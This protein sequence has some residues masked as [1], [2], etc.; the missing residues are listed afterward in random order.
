MSY[1]RAGGFCRGGLLKV[2]AVVACCLLAHSAEANGIFR[3]GVGARAAALGGADVAWAEDPLGAMAANPAG[4]GFLKSTTLNLSLTAVTASGE[5]TNLAND[6]GRLSSDPGFLPDG[7]FGIRL[8]SSPLILGIGVIPDSALSADWRY[9]D[10]PGGV[11]GTSYGVQRH[12]S[13][14]LVLRSAVGLGLSLGPHVALGATVGLVYNQNTL[15]A[16]YIFQSQP[17][18]KGLKTLLDLNTSGFGVNGSVGLLVRPHESLQLGL[19]YKS[20]TTVHSSGHASGNLG[21]QLDT[22]GLPLRRD[23]RYDA[24]VVTTF[25]QMV[26]GG[27]SWRP[28]SRWRLTLQA[29]WINWANAFD[30]LPITLTRGN[31]ADVN[32]LVGS[33]SLKDVA[34]LRWHDRFVYRVGLEYAVTDHVRLRAGYAYGKSPVP[35]STLTPLTAVIMEHTVTAGMGYGWGRYQFDLAYQ[36]DIPKERRVGVSGLQA[37]E[38]SNSRTEVLLNWVAITASIRF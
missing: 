28:H 30:E 1:R 36:L 3:N 20:P 23:F 31:N 14:I 18:L 10:T 27:V 12:K 19:T 2:S 13:E 15:Q 38:Y 9:T 34:P 16:P 33:D 29:D 35:D 32:A 24:E 5:F 17:T 22:L 25:P 8:G 37:G 6:N 26:T 4:L 21:A 7:A 11:G